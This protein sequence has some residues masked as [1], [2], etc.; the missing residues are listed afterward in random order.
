MNKQ[1]SSNQLVIMAAVFLTAF[2]NVAFFRNIA[3]S[4][5]GQ[6]HA[7]LHI[8]AV[9]LVLFCALVLF[10]LLFSG[11]LVIKPALILLLLVS[12]VSAYFMDS[13]NIVIDREMLVNAAATNSAESGD[14]L[15]PR[16]VMYMMLM[17]LVPAYLIWDIPVVR[18]SPKQAWLGRLKLGGSAL[19]VM[20]A[21]VLVFSSFF[22]SFVREHKTLRYYANPLTPIYAAYRF[23]RKGVPDG[24][25]PVKAIGTDAYIPPTDADRELVIMV[26]GETAR[27]DR[28]S[29]NGYT[30]QTNPRLEQ[31]P[32]I[33]FSHVEACGTSTAVSVPCMFDREDRED[34]SNEEAMATQNV[35]DV[36]D[37]AGVT[38]L[39]RDNNSDSKGVAAR[40]AY[41][42]FR[43]PGINPVCDTECRD[44][45]MLAG[46]QEYIDSHP[47]GDLLIVL[48]QMGSHGPAYYK[49]YPDAFRKFTPTCDSSQLDN[50]SAEEISNSYD[51]TILYTD[52]FLAEVIE[53][54]HSN[55][56][57]FETVML[58]AG[59]HGESLGEKGVY[60][61]GLP[62]WMA[63]DSQI[64]VPMIL[65][66]GKNYNDV[67]AGS[68][69]AIRDIPLSHDFIFHTLLGVFEVSSAE[70]MASKDILQAA[71]DRAGAPPKYAGNIHAE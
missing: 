11:R 40:I 29:L 25:V 68:I 49:R 61:H 54:L 66:F 64:E 10:L 8:V 26:L 34:F 20:L 41:E 52:H 32:V 42:N 44:E 50:C 15:T 38:V 4:F 60:L 58:Y 13:Y 12:A 6:P 37:H 14:L 31:E 23:S 30:R 16:F 46:L 70:Y 7:L 27:A 39:W 5:S 62:Y 45:G 36:L 67:P 65:W 47:E 33:S 57:H 59:D 69:R 17:A 28:F 24:S 1:I 63:P 3:D 53:L 9:G 21:V 43:D 2:A 48:H 56:D 35:L 18:Q 19:L 51:N 55:D 22:A 71:R